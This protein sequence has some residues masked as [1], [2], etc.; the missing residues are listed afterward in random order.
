MHVHLDTQL[1]V[2]CWFYFGNNNIV[3]FFKISL[4]YFQSIILNDYY[5]FRSNM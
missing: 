3:S 5:L 4:Q 1:Q 2:C